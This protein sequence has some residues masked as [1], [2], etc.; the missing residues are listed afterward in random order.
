V[1]A[2]G[3]LFDLGLDAALSTLGLRLNAG[4]EG[5]TGTGSVSAPCRGPGDTDRE[6]RP[7]TDSS[8]DRLLSS[9]GGIGLL[10]EDGSRERPLSVIGMGNSCEGFVG[11]AIGDVGGGE[12]PAP[13]GRGPL[14]KVMED[15]C[16]EI[17]ASD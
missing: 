12:P 6:G 9:G 14:S 17:D 4:S 3:P 2:P 11:V 8:R 15:I 16:V 7:S 5:E 13:G 1:E 10:S